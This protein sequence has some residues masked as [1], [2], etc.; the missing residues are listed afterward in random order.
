ME[1]LAQN[2]A[3]GEGAHHW[4]EGIEDRNLADG[5]AGYEFV[6]EGESYCGYGREGKEYCNAGRSYQGQGSTCGKSRNQ[7]EKTAYGKG[8]PSAHEN[9][10]P[11]A[12]SSSHQAGYGG[13]HR[14]EENHSVT[15]PAEASGCAAAEVQ[16]EDAGYSDYHAEGLPKGHPVAFKKNTGQ[17]YEDEGA[18]RVE[19][20]GA[21]GYA[22]GHSDVEE[23]VVKGGVHQGE[24]EDV[25][26]GG[27]IPGQSRVRRSN[28]IAG[29]TCRLNLEIL[30][31]NGGN[32]QNEHPCK[33]EAKPRIDHFGG[34]HFSSDSEFRKA[35]FEQRE[36][37]SPQESTSECQNRDPDLMGEN[38]LSLL[39][40]ENYRSSL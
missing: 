36:S 20:G 9:V 27:E 23:G 7:E 31:Q 22:V 35:K 1:R 26:P 15:H 40:F 28:V 32:N 12:E 30:V 4:D 34:R 38:I 3:G 2:K 19:Y 5:V 8:I 25:Q 14:V 18:H 21:G 16:G 17:D 11:L 37:P 33:G 6:V 10:H 39:H 29:L 24:G 13:A